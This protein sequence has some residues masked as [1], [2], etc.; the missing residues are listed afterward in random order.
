MREGETFSFV[1]L[2]IMILLLTEAGIALER[3]ICACLVQITP[4]PLRK[5]ELINP[6]VE[7]LTIDKL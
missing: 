2:G 1:T 6:V 3:P 5:E 4:I 7:K